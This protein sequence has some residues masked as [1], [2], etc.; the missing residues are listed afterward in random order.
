MPSQN[1]PPESTFGTALL[2]ARSGEDEALEQVLRIVEGRLKRYIEARLG[3]QLRAKL[4]DSDVLQD[5]YVQ[6]IR[7]LP[8]F[9]GQTEDD[10]VMWVTR[11]IEN[12]IRRQHRWFGAKKRRGAD[13]TSE[14]NAL[15]RVLMEPPPT[16]SAEVMAVEE[17]LLFDRALAAL[18]PDHA[19]VIELAI[20]EG[21]P[22]REVAERMGRSE[23]ATRMLLS[24]ART[25]LGLEIESLEGGNGKP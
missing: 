25:A 23:A 8:D 9:P 20:L 5:A 7:S 3:P 6:M 13:R 24:R 1:E 21:L 16:P 10:F 14:R 2:R 11:I 4:R 17:R 22:H 18:A 12:D 15:A 19:R